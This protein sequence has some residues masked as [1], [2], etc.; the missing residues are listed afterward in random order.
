MNL[1]LA[2]GVGCRGN[3]FWQMPDARVFQPRLETSSFRPGQSERTRNSR[4]LSHAPPFFSGLSA[5]R[6]QV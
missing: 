2:P 6:C 4:N 3:K 1:P 5:L